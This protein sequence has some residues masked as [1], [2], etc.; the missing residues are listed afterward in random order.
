M[1]IKLVATDMDGTFLD[2]DKNFDQKRFQK[3]YQYMQDHGIVF[4][5]A[6]GNQFDK[7]T[8]FFPRSKYPETLFV[9]ENGALIADHQKIFR[10]DTFDQAVVQKA[11]NILE[12][13]ANVKLVL[14]GTKSA[15]IRNDVTKDFYELTKLYCPTLETVKSFQDIDDDIL[16]FSVNCPIDQ[17]ELY[18]DKLAQA[19]GS[20]VSIVSSGHG[21]IDIVRHD[22]SKANGLHYLAK[23]F[24]IEPA[25]MC[26][27]GDGG[28]DLS[29]LEY[30]GHSVA[31]ENGTDI[32]LQTAD[33]HTI[34]NND[35][36]VLQ[37]LEELFEL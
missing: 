18:M 36:G 1:T 8:S 29:M 2:D 4:V 10:A 25:E 24:A 6:S 3:I 20:D 26:A 16:K 11:L 17:T 9:A 31:M 7:L 15:Y 30:V 34:N 33:H 21:D 5:C 23:K 22:V 37:H 12:N 32:V 28:N 19:L 14:C 35:Q 13:T 27:F